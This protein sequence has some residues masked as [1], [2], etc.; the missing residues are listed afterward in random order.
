MAV[1]P[2]ASRF[3]GTPFSS[4]SERGRKSV[5]LRKKGR[6][7]II[8]HHFHQSTTREIPRFARNDRGC[9]RNDMTTTQSFNPSNPSSQPLPLWMGVSPA[10]APPFVGMT[11]GAWR[12]FPSFKNHGNHGSKFPFTRCR[13]LGMLDRDVCLH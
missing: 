3:A 8:V 7:G 5:L 9:A 11:W 6:D 10:E 12:S 2:P 1:C 4:P 13:G